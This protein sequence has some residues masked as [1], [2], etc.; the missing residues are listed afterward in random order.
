M[1]D[2]IN[3]PNANGALDRPIR[4]S[5]VVSF[6]S[7]VLCVYSKVIIIILVSS[8]CNNNYHKMKIK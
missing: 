3:A 1:Y 2:S 8:N 4:F 5:D 7:D 6:K